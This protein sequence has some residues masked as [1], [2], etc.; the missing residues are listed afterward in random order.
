MEPHDNKA[1]NLST[2]VMRQGKMEE[3]LGLPQGV[4]NNK[5][6][7]SKSLDRVK[8]LLKEI[9]DSKT[10]VRTKEECQSTASCLEDLE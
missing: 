9:M 1:C 3:A 7:K 8:V 10:E 4:L 5:R 2:C 6:G